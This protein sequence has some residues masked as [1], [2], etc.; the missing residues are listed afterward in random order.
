VIFT[1]NATAAI[2]LLASSFG[3]QAGAVLLTEAE[4]NSNRLPWLSQEVV[5]LKWPPDQEFPFDEYE[6]V[7][8]RRRFK[9][10]SITAMSN[11]TGTRA[12]VGRLVAAAHRQGVPV[13]IDAAQA[14]VHRTIDVG[15]QGP[16]FLSVSLHKAYGPSG[17]GVLYASREA[18]RALVPLLGGG[19]SVDDHFEREFHWTA[20]PA[21]FEFGLQNYAAQYAVSAG[22]AFLTRFPAAAIE[23]H[24]DGLN[25]HCRRLLAELPNVRFIG[26]GGTATSSCNFYLLGVDSLRLAELLDLVGDIHVRAGKFCAHH[27][28]HRH[29]LPASVRLSFGYH[30]TLDE[31]DRCVRTLR[32]IVSH[33]LDP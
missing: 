7:L 1:A 31:V 11:V 2:N 25:G 9:L 30:N 27:Y 10:V 4:H 18:Q 26:P 32:D 17:L 23:A 15:E 5:E 3:Q 12:P 21:R 20:G 6:A 16:D 24:F 28:Y 13:H 29:G 14:A 19:G 33:Y 8:T 22:I